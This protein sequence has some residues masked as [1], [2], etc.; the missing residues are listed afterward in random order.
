MNWVYEFYDKQNQ[1]AGVYEEAISEGHRTTAAWIEIFAG[2][3]SKRVLELGAGGGQGAAATAE[4]GHSVVAV[5]LRAGACHHAR[6]LA[7]ENDR[8]MTVVE[9]DFYAVEIE[10]TFDIVTYWDGFGIGT[11]ADQRRLLKRVAG[12]LTA[13]GC[14]LFEVATP[15][16][17]ASVAGRGWEVGAAERQYSFDGEQCRGV[18][19][20]WPKGKPEE[21][22]Q[23]S[24]RCYAPA[25]FRLLLQGT[26]LYLHA[27]QPAGTV[28]WEKKRW[29]PDAPLE[30]A[31]KYVA[32]MKKVHS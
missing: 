26:G 30:Q 25:D 8:D 1:W 31:M 24:W 13:D 3:G 19:T 27:L 32:Q 7:A 18:D 15:W 5:E 16:Y 29:W 10:G 2:P 20:W 11:D 28:D 17:A 12:W 23:Q 21:A 4:L 6:K 22:V 14:A 9:G